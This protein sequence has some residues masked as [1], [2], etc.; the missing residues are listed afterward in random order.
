MHVPLPT[1]YHGHAM[2]KS[3]S[4]QLLSGPS[5]AASAMSSLTV[6]VVCVA[7]FVRILVGYQNHSGED[8]HHGSK[9]AY[10]GDYEAQRHWMELTY[11]L[12][13]GDW[14]WY[15]LQYWGLDYPPLTAYV[16]YLCGA[17]SHLMVGPQ[18]V[19]LFTSRGYE[20]DPTHK[21]F[22]RA[23]VWVLDAVIYFPAAYCIL[24]TLWHRRT[25]QQ[26]TKSG[27][28]VDNEFVTTY[29]LALLQPSI[30][31]IDHGH[32]QYNAVA[33]G[34]ALWSFYYIAHPKF[35]PSCIVG[36]I[37]FCGALN[38]K[39][40]TLYYAPVIF[41]YLLGRCFVPLKRNSSS[42]KNNLAMRQCA[43]RFVALGVTVIVSFG[44]LWWPFLTYSPSDNLILVGTNSS[45]LL[46]RG[47]HVLHR[48]FPLERGLFEGKVANIWCALDTKP[49]NIRDRIPSDI[50]PLAALGVTLLLML[51]SCI[52]MF[53]I[54]KNAEANDGQAQQQRHASDLKS[55]LWGST[56]CA[57]AF[58]LA[59]FQVHEKSI[60]LALAPASLL[61]WEDALFSDWF[62]VAATWTMWPLLT[63]DR[64]Q[65]AYSCTFVIFGTAV[66]QLRT[67]V[68]DKSD[69][70]SWSSWCWRA[71]FKASFLAMFA[72]HALENVITVPVNLPDLFPVLWSIGGCGLCCLA[73]L[74]TIWALS[75]VLGGIS[76]KTK[77]D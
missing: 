27:S 39:Q 29:L 73:W 65:V 18:T 31:L 77:H 58:F 67:M 13:M 60:L 46:D 34:L 22:M 70:E 35:F 7:L 15:D 54:G 61:A 51:P 8:N 17:L 41:A 37:C 56:S 47:K 1:I 6:F 12:P 52:T 20:G 68:P 74:R 2:V 28:I 25:K 57:L 33:L 19:A 4:K 16:S 5:P 30:I 55:L 45:T 69:T 44:A 72:L 66:S 23:T 59:S 14:Y 50:Q 63:I 32:F 9:M 71:L 40:M 42:S 11:H 48:I 21:A 64:L 3:S 38:F 76:G 49:I 75:F 36:S 53:F 26:Q 62:A 10:G 43:E 24:K